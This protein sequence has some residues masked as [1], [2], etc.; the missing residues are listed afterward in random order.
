[1]NRVTRVLSFLVVLTAI[2]GCGPLEDELPPSVQYEA[3]VTPDT[4]GCLPTPEL[5]SFGRMIYVPA[6]SHIYHIHEGNDFQ[7]TVTLSIRNPFPWRSLT[8]TRVDYFDSS[9]A[10][11]RSYLNRPRILGPMETL[12]YVVAQNDE[13]G[14]SGAN[15]L[16]TW[17]GEEGEAGPITEAVMIGTSSGQGLSFVTV[18]REIRRD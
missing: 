10:C 3:A 13:T 18:G 6:Y 7:L 5:E 14:G 1:M 8:I 15:S 2:W 16:V 4:A 11:V 12:E 17:N 9:G